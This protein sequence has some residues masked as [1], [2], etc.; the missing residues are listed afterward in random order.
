MIP[1]L[2]PETPKGANLHDLKSPQRYTITPV[3]GSY[4]V[5]GLPM[6]FAWS[7]ISVLASA[8]GACTVSFTISSPEAI[9][10]GQAI[11]HEWDQGEVIGAAWHEWEN[12]WLAVR[13]DCTTP[14]RVEIATKYG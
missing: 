2:V 9:N 12:P 13:I 4:H 10:A 6:R 8:G 14:T 5:I 11:W 1:I 3:D 7:T